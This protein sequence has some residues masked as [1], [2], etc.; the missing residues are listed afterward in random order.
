MYYLCLISYLP[1][2]PKVLCKASW[3][4]MSGDT[5]R[6]NPHRQRTAAQKS[7]FEVADS[8]S[9]CFCD[10]PACGCRPQAGDP[11]PLPKPSPTPLPKPSPTPEPIRWHELA[12]F[13]GGPYPS[14]AIFVRTACGVWWMWRCPDP[15]VCGCRGR[16]ADIFW[17]CPRRFFTLFFTH[18]YFTYY[19]CF[20]KQQQH[21]RMLVESRIFCSI[22]YF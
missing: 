16:I 19:Y 4:M 11:T 8:D 22:S 12:P 6:R 5:I 10:D 21:N 9:E 1:F 20:G 14:D 13:L 7:S 15:S 2:L 3:A 18:Y 17:S